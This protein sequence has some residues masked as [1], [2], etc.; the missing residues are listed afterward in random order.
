MLLSNPIYR[1]AI[2]K[3]EILKLKYSET[4][5]SKFIKY[6]FGNTLSVR[7]MMTTLSD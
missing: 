1:W 7:K 5:I 4:E 2:E 6:C 3:S